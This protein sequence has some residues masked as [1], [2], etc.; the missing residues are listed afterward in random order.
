MQKSLKTSDISKEHLISYIKEIW[1]KYFLH[2]V[3]SKK[4]FTAKL[5]LKKTP[6]AQLMVSM[7]CFT[8]SQGTFEEIY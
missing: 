6:K 8:L 3:S 7:K 5:N 1:G 4:T 2:I